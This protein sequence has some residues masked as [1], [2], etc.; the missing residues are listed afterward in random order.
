MTTIEC[1]EVVKTIKKNTVIDHI[2]LQMQSGSIYGLQGI[3]GSGKTML[4]RL[5]SGLIYPTSGEILINGKHLGKDLTFPESLGLLLENPAFLDNYTGL[6]NLWQLASIKRKI[7][8][9]RIR[10]VVKEVGLNPDDSKK[11]KKYSLGMKQ[12]IGI[13]AAYMEEPDIV[14]MDEPTNA[15]DVDGIALFKQILQHEKERGALVIISCHD[16]EI[17]RELTDEIFL[18]KDGRLLEH[19]VPGAPAKKMEE[20]T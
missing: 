16:L 2:T 14:I 3:N 8:K 7:S 4:M 1:H 20:T 17:L 9:E 5:I 15:L 6:E 11:Y 18:L 19:I 12:R 13:A 10:E